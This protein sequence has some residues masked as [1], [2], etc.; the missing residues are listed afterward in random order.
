MAWVYVPESAEPNLRLVSG[1]NLSVTSKSTR[2]AKKSSNQKCR[3]PLFGTNSGH[4][5]GSLGVDQLISSLLVSRARTLALQESAQAWM[6]SEAVFF[7]KW[8]ESSGKSG[9]V[10]YSLRTYQGYVDTLA[11]LKGSWPMRAMSVDGMLYPLPRLEHGTY[12]KDGFYLLPTLTASEG[13][14]NKGGGSGR[15]GKERPSLTTIVQKNL[16]PTLTVCGNYNKKGLSKNSGDGR[17]TKICLNG[18]L[19]NPEWAEWYMGFPLGWTGVSE[20]N[21]LRRLEIA[22]YQR[23]RAKR[24]SGS[25]D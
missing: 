8:Q 10:S 25:A 17:I 12:E 18:G 13:G 21:A 6:E 20:P 14:Y 2:T 9:P 4:S 24:S 1:L 5:T 22:W 11:K 7:S 19:L 23:K 3:A 16:L 15:V